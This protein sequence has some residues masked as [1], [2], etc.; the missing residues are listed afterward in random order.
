MVFG[1]ISS[2]R[3]CL[4]AVPLL[5]LI[6]FTTVRAQS[7]SFTYQGRLTDGG[8]AANGN[9]D[10][11]F[12]LWDSASGGTQIGSTQG[13]NAVAV[14]NGVFAVVL[15]FGANSFS[16]ANRFLEISARPGGAGS[17]TLLT[18]RQPLSSTPYA[19]RSVSAANADAATLATTATNAAQLGGIAANQYV[20][21]ND[22][23]L[24][25]SRTPIAGS[26]NY[27]Q[28]NPGAAQSANFNISGNGT[29]GGSLSAGTQFNIGSNR[30]LSIS[31]AGTRANSNTF[32]GV[33]SGAANVPNVNLPNG[34]LNSFF[35]AAAGAANSTGGANS[36]FG[37]SA[38]NANT[39]GLGNSFFG[40]FAGSTNTTSQF[41]SFFGNNAGSHNTT[42]N[43]NSF[44]GIEAGEFNDTGGQNVFI[45]SYAGD[46]NTS[47]S[48]NV[49]V[50]GFAV[51]NSGPD[52]E[53][54]TTTGATN[55][56]G[57]H[58]TLLGNGA[59][60]A[61]G[62]LTNASAIGF[63]AQVGQSNSLVLGS[64][65][66]VNFATADTNVGIGTTLPLKRLEVRTTA[67]ADG[68]NLVGN[69]SAFFLSDAT[70]AEKAA[71]GY[72]GSA[73]L[74]STDAAAGDVVLRTSSG[75]LL[76][77]HGTGG[78]S[79]ILNSSG[80]VTL[81]TVGAGST[82]LCRNGANEISNCSSSL[83]YK[84]NVATFSDGLNVIYRL[85]PISFNWKQDG[86][87]DIGL[88]A[89]EVEKVEPLL[90]FRNPKGEIEGVKYNQ[91]SAV[92]INAIKE[93]Q[94]QIETLRAQNAE[95]NARLNLIEKTMR[96]RHSARPRVAR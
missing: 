34:N 82:Q 40:A 65:N 39:S 75:R 17:F 36:F 72:A 58:N 1:R 63:L 71:L 10:L 69:G 18:P 59:D 51:L 80:T 60:V 55:T 89:E 23:R 93:Q 43:E 94:Q 87:K 62:N 11:Q 38:G 12:A 85:R 13:L 84:T 56:T 27:I 29:V 79:L 95:L 91:L 9:Y 49:F 44:V 77:Q 42:G 88:G 47:G 26:L 3:I 50:G 48:S 83:R 78:A 76:L 90:T 41:N 4:L 73:G 52:F 16:G 35:G 28:T 86:V 25:D 46:H 37:H 81:P 22:S 20:L 5:A 6:S 70:K 2:A 68:I 24:S 74:Y 45:G 53:S 92:F 21:A 66:G 14:T 32:L 67:V 96:K 7:S 54:G 64:I 61:T 57:S 8:T 33:G 31:G 19:L 30:V 15:D